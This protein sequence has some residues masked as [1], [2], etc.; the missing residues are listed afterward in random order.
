MRLLVVRQL[1][2][3]C[4]HKIMATVGN[5]AAAIQ[6]SRVVG[7]CLHRLSRYCTRMLCVLT[8]RLSLARSKL[9]SAVM[10][11]KTRRAATV[12][13]E[14]APP[15][16]SRKSGKAVASDGGASATTALAAAKADEIESREQQQQQQPGQPSYYLMKVRG[17]HVHVYISSSCQAHHYSNSRLFRCLC[18]THA[19]NLSS[20]LPSTCAVRA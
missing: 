7:N 12:A 11:P 17:R 16:R 15:K 20:S 1:C 4:E 6:A 18:F 19:L 2:G 8:S 13:A 14:P 9:F 3:M 5:A 10:A